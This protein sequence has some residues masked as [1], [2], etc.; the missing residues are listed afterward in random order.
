[1]CC[2]NEGNPVFLKIASVWR[3]NIPMYRLIYGLPI[4][5]FCTSNDFVFVRYSQKKLYL[6][7]SP[8]KITD[9]FTLRH[10]RSKTET[11]QGIIVSR[12]PWRTKQHRELKSLLRHIN[13]QHL[14]GCCNFNVLSNPNDLFGAKCESKNLLSISEDNRS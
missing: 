13:H 14:R 6:V 8:N 11:L 2:V 1:M 4:D 7:A 12:S 5:I 10:L 3:Q 9:F